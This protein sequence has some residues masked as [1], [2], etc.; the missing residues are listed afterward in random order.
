MPDVAPGRPVSGANSTRKTPRPSS[1]KGTVRRAER[2]SMGSQ[3]T[4]A[5]RGPS[6]EGVANGASAH[7]ARLPLLLGRKVVGETLGLLPVSVAPEVAYRSPGR[8]GL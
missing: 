3:R 1:P 6:T 4:R 7:M 8:L 5:G 2:T